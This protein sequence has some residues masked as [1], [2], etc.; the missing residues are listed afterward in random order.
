MAIYA[1][2]MVSTGSLDPLTTIL[3]VIPT[4]FHKVTSHTHTFLHMRNSMP[5]YSARVS[6]MAEGKESWE[7]A[8]KLLL[9]AVD[10]VL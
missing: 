1:I 10:V 2:A 7:R 3:L 6:K 5:V 4:H 8:K 9:G